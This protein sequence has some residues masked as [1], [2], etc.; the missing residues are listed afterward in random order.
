[1]L[2]NR[3]VNDN[4][5]VVLGP[6]VGAIIAHGWPASAGTIH[7]QRARKRQDGLRRFSY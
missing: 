5:Q 1:M 7:F 4:V 2:A 6:A 3:F